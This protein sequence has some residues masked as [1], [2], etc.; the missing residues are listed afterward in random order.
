M[1]LL[2]AKTEL[3]TSLTFDAE[4]GRGHA[5]Y[6]LGLFY[7]SCSLLLSLLALLP[8]HPH[9]IICLLLLPLPICLL[10]YFFALFT[11]H[12]WL[13]PLSSILSLICLHFLSILHNLSYFLLTFLPPLSSFLLPSLLFHSPPPSPAYSFSVWSVLAVK[14]KQEGMKR[15][16][17]HAADRAGFTCKASALGDDSGTQAGAVVLYP[18]HVKSW[19]PP[20]SSVRARSRFISPGT[21]ECGTARRPRAARPPTVAIVTLPWEKGHTPMSV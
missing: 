2:F 6:T 1:A 7:Y 17:C 10:V 8:P 11:L 12:F 14:R 3:K 13:P 9:I 5:L 15:D 21:L 18:E 4:S 20:K 16:L 19:S